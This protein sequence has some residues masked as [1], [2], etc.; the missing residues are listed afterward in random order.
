MHILHADFETR[1]VV[2]LKARG[3]HNYV[4]HPLTEPWCMSYAFDAQPVQRWLIGEPLPQDVRDYIMNGGTLYAHNAA[5]ERAVWNAIMH[6]R[7][8]WP[9]LQLEQVVCTMVMAYAMGLP[10]ALEK[11]SAACGL[12][13]AKD[14]AGHRLMLKWAQPKEMIGETPIWH[15]DWQEFERLLAYCDTDVEAERELTG[16]LIALSP[17]EQNVY[18]LDQRINDR[19]IYVDTAAVQTAIKV[20]GYTQERLA[21][22]LY[23]AT[24]GFVGLPTETARLTKW[25]RSRN[26][27]TDGVAKADVLDLLADEALPDDVRTAL[28]IRQEAGKT[29]VAKLRPMIDAAGPDSRLRGLFQMDG[30][31][32]G[33]WAARRVQPHNF[34]RP[35]MKQADIDRVLDWLAVPTM[36]PADLDHFI[37]LTYGPPLTV[38]SYAL[39][40]MLTAGPGNHLMAADFSNIE[41][42]GLAW[43]AGEAWKLQAFRDYD[44]GIGPDLYVLAYAKT[45][46][47]PVE[48]VTDEMRQIGKVMELA[49]GYGG[50]LGAF[51]TMVKTYPS[52]KFT[53]D[54]VKV[55]NTGWRTAHARTKA[56]WYALE[57]AAIAA[58]DNEGT[59]HSAGAPGNEV[60]FRKLG[61]FLWCRLPSGRPLCY[62]YPEVR[63]VETPW[64]ELKRALTYKTLLDSQARK[65]AKIVPDPTNKGEWWRISTYGGSLSENIVQALSRDVL[66]EAMLRIDATFPIVFHVHDEIVAEVP[67]TSA[68]DSLKRFEQLMCERPAWAQDFPIVAKGWRGKRYRK[69]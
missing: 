4:L 38:I 32:T 61:S 33:R 67:D 62:P 65:K 16:R 25:I 46:G 49:F 53:P 11:A 60:I 18:R 34:P 69:S 2:D 55:W 20:A 1:S 39:R 10:G 14:M 29:S 15:S 40:G 13:H 68:A 37:D 24:A 35:K 9:R 63:E 41:G 36:K 52:V 51:V 5:F 43:A 56:Y 47:I 27:D 17:K 66:A 64:G 12:L 8:G 19:G 23:A 28:L 44:A 26:V 6:R 45:F 54:L 57:N 50:A 42:R 58:T 30:A 21:Q 31:G 3:L 59:M 48:D 22:S 7:F